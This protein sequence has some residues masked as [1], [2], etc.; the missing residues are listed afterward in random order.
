MTSSSVTLWARRTTLSTS[1]PSGSPRPPL[2]N[3]AR[4][5]EGEVLPSPSRI[6]LTNAFRASPISDIESPVFKLLPRAR[7]LRGAYP[8]RLQYRRC[9]A[10]HRDAPHSGQGDDA[11]V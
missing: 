11:P 3:A 1:A 8:N 2:L 9:D 6:R 5:S 4:R 10:S 7:T